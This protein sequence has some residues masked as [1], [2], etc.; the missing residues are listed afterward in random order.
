MGVMVK[1]KVARFLWTTVYITASLR[2]ISSLR[3]FTNQ[4]PSKSVDQ[5]VIQSDCLLYAKVPSVS[6][7]F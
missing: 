7:Q 5:S 4:L 6:E 2:I 3:S 1:N